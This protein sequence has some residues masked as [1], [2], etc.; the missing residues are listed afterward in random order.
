MALSRAAVVVPR[1]LAAHPVP[2]LTITPV[3][4]HCAVELPVRRASALVAPQL[5][6]AFRVAPD[7]ELRAAGTMGADVGDVGDDER[8]QAADAPQATRV[9]TNANAVC[10]YIDASSF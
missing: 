2:V 5:L 9:S 1:T 10:R 8:L 7:G 3:N 4:A 6:S